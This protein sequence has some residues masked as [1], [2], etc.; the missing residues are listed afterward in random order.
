MQISLII[1]GD[2]LWG[3][4]YV[5]SHLRQVGRGTKW[6]Q[7]RKNFPKPESVAIIISRNQC[8]NFCHQAVGKRWNADYSFGSCDLLT[9][10]G[11]IWHLW[12]KFT[13]FIYY[14]II[15]KG[16]FYPEIPKLAQKALQ[17]ANSGVGFCVPRELNSASFFWSLFKIFAFFWTNVYWIF[18]RILWIGKKNCFHHNRLIFTNPKLVLKIWLKNCPKWRFWFAQKMRKQIFLRDRPF[19]RGKIGFNCRFSPRCNSQIWNGQHRR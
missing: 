1:A 17:F 15:E 2:F 5:P 14:E 18:V 12:A 10:L 3:S 19:L 8:P 4:A 7:S 13:L 9:K 6:S 11:N 16:I